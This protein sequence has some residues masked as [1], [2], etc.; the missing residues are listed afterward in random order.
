MYMDAVTFC[1][2]VLVPA[3]SKVNCFVVRSYWMSK[4]VT[5]ICELSIQ[6]V[7]PVVFNTSL[8][9]TVMAKAP[10]TV[11]PASHLEAE[12]RGFILVAIT[13]YTP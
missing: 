10:R 2:F 13:I 12:S 6:V 4:T 3:T 8:A 9:D 7:K 11:I 1:S 5:E